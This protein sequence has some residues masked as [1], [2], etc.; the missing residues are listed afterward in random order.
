[1][2]EP[3]LHVSCCLL[4][5]PLQ[6]VRCPALLHRSSDSDCRRNRYGSTAAPA[7]A[8]AKESSNT[9]MGC[10]SLRPPCCLSVERTRVGSVRASFGHTARR[11]LGRC[12]EALAGTAEK[13]TGAHAV[14][15]ICAAADIARTCLV[16]FSSG[17]IL[18]E[19]WL[20]PQ[21]T[22]GRGGAACLDASGRNVKLAGA[23]ANSTGPCGRRRRRC[24]NIAV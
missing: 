9:A 24:S 19:D 2:S 7:P 14:Y 13:K 10:S 4:R 6:F 23:T 15:R 16:G 5:S 17:R 12:E 21:L 3:P 1:M 11:R 22:S 18:V 8:F 20:L